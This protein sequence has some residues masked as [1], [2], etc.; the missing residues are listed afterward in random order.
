MH[1]VKITRSIA[2]FFSIYFDLLASVVAVWID[3][4]LSPQLFAGIRTC[5]RRVTLSWIAWA[6]IVLIAA[7]TT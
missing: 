6:F 3:S 5:R 1:L 2:N 7:W 4:L